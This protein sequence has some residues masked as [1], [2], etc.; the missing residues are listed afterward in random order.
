MIGFQDTFFKSLQWE[1]EFML[2]IKLDNIYNIVLA[3]HFS[4]RFV[5][6]TAQTRTVIDFVYDMFDS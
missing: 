2:S 5:A 3:C 1:K 4:S 6:E